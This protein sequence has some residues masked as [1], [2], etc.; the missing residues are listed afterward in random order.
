MLLEDLAPSIVK[1]RRQVCEQDLRSGR[2]EHP[3][4]SIQATLRQAVLSGLRNTPPSDPEFD[5]P[6]HDVHEQY[7]LKS[8][9]TLSH[10]A[11]LEE[12]LQGETSDHVVLD[13]SQVEFASR[14]RALERLAAYSLPLI[15][16]TNV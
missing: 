1:L 13:G 16:L 3:R 15:V 5:L 2:K 9:A 7:R 4:H 6:S 8:L 14:L 11:Q 10:L 12:V